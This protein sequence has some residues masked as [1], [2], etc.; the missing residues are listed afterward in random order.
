MDDNKALE[1]VNKIFNNV[2]NQDNKYTLDELTE[3]FAFDIN[4][5]KQV[6]DSTTGEITWSDNISSGKFITNDNMKKRDENEGWMLP[7]KDINNLQELIDTWNQINLMTTERNYD[8]ENVAKSDTIFRST[9]VYGSTECTNV[10]NIIYCDGCGN[11]EF[12]LASKES[13]S[14]NFC[15]RAMDSINCSNSYN[16]ICSDKIS[17]SLFIQD[18]RDL[19]ECMFCAHIVEKKYCIANMQFEKEEYFEIKKQIIEWILNS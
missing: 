19:Y 7:K 10:K 8:S 3:K 2:F 11:S 18:C 13:G 15:I 1:I 14:C 6:I 5:P 9:N 16:I 12:L 4:L 17:E